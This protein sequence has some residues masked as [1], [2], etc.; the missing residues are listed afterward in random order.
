MTQEGHVA[1]PDRDGSRTTGNDQPDR[2]RQR[3]HRPPSAAR[4]G[5]CYDLPPACSVTTSGQRQV[6]GD[7]VVPG[8]GTQAHRPRPTVLS[9]PSTSSGR[10]KPDDRF[11]EDSDTSR[12]ASAARSSPARSRTGR[13]TSHLEPEW[14]ADFYPIQDDL[15]QRCLIAHTGQPAVR[16][17]PRATRTSRR[18]PMI[19]SALAVDHPE[20][21]P[22]PR[23]LAGRRVTADLSTRRST[24]TRRIPVPAFTKTAVTRQELTTES[25]LPFT[26]RVREPGRRSTPP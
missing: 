20:Q 15:R 9:T 26:T 3:V 19:P 24:T 11:T 17:C 16:G 2:T 25:G 1:Q 13:R 23:E 10:R 6:L 18:S 14:S 7:G 22:P 4:H 5:R 21:T 12:P 8:P